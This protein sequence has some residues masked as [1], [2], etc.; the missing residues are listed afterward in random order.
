MKQNKNLKDRRRFPRY[1]P[2][3]SY[4]P[5]V[6][7]EFKGNT[8]ITINTINISKGGLMGYT[9]S[10]EQF[11]GIQNQDIEIIEIIFPDKKPFLCSGR[12]LRLQPSIVENKCFC[13]VEFDVSDSSDNIDVIDVSK[14]FDHRHTTLKRT[15]SDHELIQRV[16][17]L[18]NYYHIEDVDK[19]IELRQQAYNSFDDITG[20][21]T[22]EEKWWFYEMLDEMKR[23]EPNYPDVLK[24][25]FLK[26]CR[27][28]IKQS[29]ISV[30]Q[31]KKPIASF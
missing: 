29:L 25:A 18:E 11:L 6:N 10:I 12:I 19:E 24:Q 31:S 3:K 17:Q 8:K 26:L 5:K 4:S 28:G 21:L 30:K 13:A 23:Q 16:Q 2:T 1:Y 27:T 9:S 22:I 14:N 7:F 15:V 20:H